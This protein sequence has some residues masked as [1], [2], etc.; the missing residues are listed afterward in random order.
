ME[1]ETEGD[2]WELR[3]KG[4]IKIETVGLRPEGVNGNRARRGFLE[5][6]QAGVDR[7]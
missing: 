2:L 7:K 6:R 3:Q 5:I 4:L 1:I